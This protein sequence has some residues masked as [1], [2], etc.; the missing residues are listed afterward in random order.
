M[1][2]YWT[3]GPIKSFNKTFPSLGIP[4]VGIMKQN[5]RLG[6]NVV[7]PHTFRVDPEVLFF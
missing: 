7:L 3:T 5:S 4:L 2:T 6:M 1:D